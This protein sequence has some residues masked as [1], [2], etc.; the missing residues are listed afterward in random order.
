M[1]NAGFEPTHFF[2][3]GLLFLLQHGKYQEKPAQIIAFLCYLFFFII[4]QNSLCL[5]QI[6]QENKRSI[7]YKIVYSVMGN[8]IFNNC[9]L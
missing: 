7:L 6:L 9:E 4:P 8:L 5:P 3:I 2:S 1:K